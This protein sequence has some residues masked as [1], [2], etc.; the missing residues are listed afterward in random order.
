MLLTRLLAHFLQRFD[1]TTIYKQAQ[2]K[3]KVITSQRALKLLFYFQEIFPF[4]IQMQ[5]DGEI[6]EKSFFNFFPFTGFTNNRLKVSLSL[7]I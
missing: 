3:L 7:P 2:I 5:N 6:I 1:M 4:K